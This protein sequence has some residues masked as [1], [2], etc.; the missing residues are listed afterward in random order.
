ML[1]ATVCVCVYKRHTRRFIAMMLAAKPC[2]LLMLQFVSLLSKSVW[3]QSTSFHEW[4]NVG[5]IE[6]MLAAVPQCLHTSGR[7]RT[8]SMNQAMSVC[9]CTECI[10][11]MNWHCK[12][13]ACSIFVSMYCRCSGDRIWCFQCAAFGP[14]GWRTFN[15]SSDSLLQSHIDHSSQRVIDCRLSSQLT[16]MMFG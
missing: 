2:M 3:T 10:I 9:L 5:W 1:R 4:E 12:H 13:Y 8:P 14:N 16:F 7:L 11:S 15:Q 6:P